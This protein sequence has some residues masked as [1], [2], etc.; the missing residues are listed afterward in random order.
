MRAFRLRLWCP[1][2]IIIFALFN[3]STWNL[4]RGE[5]I[6]IPGNVTLG[7]LFPI[8]TLDVHGRC[9][10]S[11]GLRTVQEIEAMLYALDKINAD[12]R[13]LPNMK[14]GMKAFDTC[15]DRTSALN[16]AVKEFV[17]GNDWDST[18]GCKQ[19]KRPVI[20]VVGPAYSSEAV[21]ITPVMNLFEIP[22][23]SHSATSAKLSDKDEYEFFSRTV[24]SDDFQVQAIIDLLV[25]FN[26]TY[27]SLLYT[28]EVYGIAGYEGLEKNA[29]E[30][31]RGLFGFFV[32]F[33]LFYASSPQWQGHHAHP[34]L[35]RFHD[36]YS[37]ASSSHICQTVIRS[38]RE[39]YDISYTFLHFTTGIQFANDK[40]SVPTKFDKEI[41]EEVVENVL[42]YPKAKVLILFGQ[43]DAIEQLLY[44]IQHHAGNKSLLFVCSDSISAA[45]SEDWNKLQLIKQQALF[46][47]LP[48]QQSRNF[49]REF[50]EY[51]LNLSIQGN[52]RNP[53]FKEFSGTV[54]TDFVK[55]VPLV[56][57][58]VYAFAHA[59][60]HILEEC[61]KN[62]SQRCV[63]RNKISGKRLLKLIR[64]QDFLSPSGT[65][66]NFTAE[67]DVIGRLPWVLS[68]SH[69]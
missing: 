15:G 39:L 41:Y 30:K 34:I 46:I 8:R 47:N 28:E 16:S 45:I 55:S 38:A 11:N 68:I 7:A 5:R 2:L 62:T 64:T 36:F 21:H 66:V 23:I 27:V 3:S 9:S 57:D 12:E 54:R 13:L 40:T 52:Q 37:I 22:L 65:V 59:L 43:D 33:A 51:F 58:A 60:H 26:W 14:L 6:I 53:W 67:G 25:Y 20:G 50:E 61:E 18:D 10:F 29:K 42:S 56:V 1:S 32:I 17:L 35:L 48:S 31:G 69:H 4:A 63:S 24:T 49:T 44:M 19:P